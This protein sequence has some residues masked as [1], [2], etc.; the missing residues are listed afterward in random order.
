MQHFP[1]AYINAYMGNTRRIVSAD[2]KDQVAGLCVG[3][4]YRGG[5]VVKSLGAQPARIADTALRQHPGHEAGAIKR[6]VWIAAALDIRIADVLLRLRNKRRKGFIFQCRGRDI[7][8]TGRFGVLVHIAGA[9]EQI[10]P[11]SQR[12]Q[13]DRI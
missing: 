10:F 4:G 5:N 3:S 7:I 13:I 11:V 6:S 2:E 9:G 12:C 1:T 8:G